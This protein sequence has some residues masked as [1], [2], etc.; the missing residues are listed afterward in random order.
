MAGGLIPGDE[1]EYELGARLDVGQTTALNFGTDQACDEVVARL[2]PSGSDESID[3]G[4]EFG[5]GTSEPFAPL[6]AVLCRVGAL[7]DFI[8]PA[9]PEQVILRRCAQ[10]MGDHV[11]GHQHDVVGQEIG[12]SRLGQNVVEQLLA[13]VTAK[14]LDPAQTM[15]GDGRVDDATDLAVARSR[16][17][18][19]QLLFVGHDDS[20]LTKAGDKGVGVL[21]SGQQ[22][23]EAGRNQLPD[24]VRLTG[25]SRRRRANSS[26]S[27]LAVNG[28]NIGSP[29]RIQ[30]CDTQKRYRPDAFGS[31]LWGP[32]LLVAN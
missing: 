27:K 16:D 32:P 10:Q 31:R 9:G 1:E 18:V 6:G 26:E 14:G 25:S 7:N 11:V 29:G 15:D 4:H 24:G 20:G 2:S 12:R 22:V 23:V 19:Y 13:Q 17:L 3:I 30:R 5:V 21:G 8:G 28:S